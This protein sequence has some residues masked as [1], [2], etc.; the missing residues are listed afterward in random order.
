MGR[1]TFDKLVSV[2]QRKDSD[3][4]GVKY[5]VFDLADVGTFE[6]RNERLHDLYPPLHVVPVV[7]FKL[8]SNDDLRDMEEQ[9]VA[10]GGEGCVIRRPG[11]KY[12]PGRSGDVIKIKRLTKDV[13]RWSG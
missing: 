10:N 8:F 5:M 13:E 6:E 2:I 3:W 4:Q 11:C 12:R 1:G 9:I 7:H